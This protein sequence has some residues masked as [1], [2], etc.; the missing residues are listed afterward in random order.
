MKNYENHGKNIFARKKI[1][2][3]LYNRRGGKTFYSLELHA[4]IFV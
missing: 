2:S 3:Y 4:R 1:L